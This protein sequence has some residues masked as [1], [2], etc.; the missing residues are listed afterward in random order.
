MNWMKNQKKLNLAVLMGLV[1]II[2]ALS[3]WFV[4][5]IEIKGKEIILATQDLRLE[6]V[7]RYEGALQWWKNAYVTTIFPA[8]AILTISGIVTMLS[9]QLLSRFT[10]KNG[11]KKFEEIIKQ[12]CQIN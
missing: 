11:L 6:E 2:A 8:T 3:I 12:S 4:S 7:W 1:L 9:P 10:K 5:I